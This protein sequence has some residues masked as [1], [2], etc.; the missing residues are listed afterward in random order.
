MGKCYAVCRIAVAALLF[1]G[2]S[3]GKLKFKHNQV[4]AGGAKGSV[5]VPYKLE[6]TGGDDAAT[7][8]RLEFKGHGLPDTVVNGSFGNQ[9][10]LVLN[11]AGVDTGSRSGQVKLFDG[12]GK[13]LDTLSVKLVITADGNE[14][15]GYQDRRRLSRAVADS[16]EGETFTDSDGLIDAVRNRLSSVFGLAFQDFKELDGELIRAFI[17]EQLTEL[18]QPEP[19]MTEA[20]EETCR[21]DLEKLL[22]EKFNGRSFKDLYIYAG[23]CDLAR[24]HALK[25]RDDAALLLYREAMNHIDDVES[26]WSN[27]L[28]QISQILLKRLNPSSTRDEIIAVLDRKSVV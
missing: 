20:Q 8:Y 9:P 4:F 23:L 17:D 12:N 22:N 10:A 25:G 6:S 1:C 2:V 26:A 24:D 21:R 11:T 15:T 3:R 7:A 18:K 19:Q 28:F 14:P 13:V 27:T 5:T 16:L